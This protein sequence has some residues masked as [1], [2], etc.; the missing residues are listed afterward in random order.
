[1]TVGKSFSDSGVRTF[2]YLWLI[3]KKVFLKIRYDRYRGAIG[4]IYVKNGEIKVGDEVM[5][6]HTGKQYTVKGLSVLT[7]EEIPVNIL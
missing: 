1:M 2:I 4:M 3:I 5:W 7:P 6:C